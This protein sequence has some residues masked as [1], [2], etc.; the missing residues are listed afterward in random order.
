MKAGSFDKVMAPL[1]LMYPH[2]P[3]GSIGWRMGYGENYADAFYSWFY[4]LSQEEKADY[5]RRFPKPICWDLTESRLLRR[6]KFW[7]YKWRQDGRPAYSFDM[8]YEEEEA[9]I[10]RDPIF[11]WGHRPSRSG[12]VGK[13]CFSQWYP[14]DFNVGHITYCCMEQYMMSKKA[15]LFGDEETNRRIMESKEPGKIK[16]LGRGVR[17]F[18]EEIWESFRLPIVLTGNYYKFSQLPALRAA[19]LGTGE[20]L[21][22][23]AS[24]YDA[25]WGIGM[26]AAKASACPVRCWPGA[27][28][29]G[30]SLMEVRDE[31]DR[32]WRHGDEIDFSALHSE[33][34]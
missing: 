32:L 2:I 8:I 24:P 13:E 15:L 34:D 4:G 31:L 7:I 20:S 10:S 18:K 17:G 21:L 33:F 25:L 27:N 30:F 14:A 12:Y 26:D 11:F 6:E 23:E 5:E 22:V 9:G 29:L 19:L 1:W 3:Q 28:L 16:E